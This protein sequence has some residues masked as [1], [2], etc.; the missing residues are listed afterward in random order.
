MPHRATPHRG[1]PQADAGG[2]VMPM[3]KVI[4]AEE[5]QRELVRCREKRDQLIDQIHSLEQQIWPLQ[6]ELRNIT[7]RFDQLAELAKRFHEPSAS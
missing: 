1:H 7:A 2:L 5:I 3:S 4:N 6:D